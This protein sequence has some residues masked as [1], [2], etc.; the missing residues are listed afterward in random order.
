MEHVPALGLI[1]ALALGLVSLTLVARLTQRNAPA[2]VTWL[3]IALLLYNLWIAG[4]LVT[5][6]LQ[7]RVVPQPALI[8][9][10][11]LVLLA[12]ILAWLYAHVTQLQAFVP[13]LS[14]RGVR[15]VRYVLAAAAGT[16][17]AGWC[18]S[19]VTGNRAV[20]LPLAWI[21]RM[22]V[23]PAALV[24][25]LL[26]VVAA[27]RL[28]DQA[29]RARFS[30]LGAAYV[31]LFACVSALSSGWS[32]LAAAAPELPAALDVMLELLYNIVAIVWVT[33]MMRWLE[34][35]PEV[36]TNSRVATPR[37]LSRLFAERG[38]TKREAEII[39]L[40]CLGKT[41]Q[42]IADRLFISLTT[43]KDHNYVTFQKLGVRNRTELTRLVL[44]GPAVQPK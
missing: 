31:G 7:D 3:P 18:L 32:G 11:R 43:V 27:R 34:Q 6:Y 12:L 16:L 20:L 15:A 5:A 44:G 1:L 13:I 4:F 24:A 40:I 25:S 37:D 33:R 26:F 21:V 14:V 30:S 42:E 17:I 2:G 22:A 28:A 19:L 29:W 38:I 36:R 35:S 8:D 10:M 23:F 41:N 9:A 39:E